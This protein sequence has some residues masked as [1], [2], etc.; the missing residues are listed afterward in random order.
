M[1]AEKPNPGKLERGA[2]IS[3]CE[4]LGRIGDGGFGYI[5]KVRRDGKVYALK[6]A[7][8]RLAD[9]PAEDRGP[10][11]ERLH[12]EVAALMTLHHPNIVRIHSFDR[13]PE[14]EDGYPYLVMDYVEGSCIYEWRAEAKPSLAQI[15]MVFEKIAG[16]VGHMHRL[17]IC[18]RDLKSANVIVRPD[19]E[20]VIVDFGLARS[21]VAYGVTQASSI[22]TL[23]HYPPEYAAYCDSAAYSRQP[24]EWPPTTDIYTL[25]YVLYVTL[26]GETPLTVVDENGALSEVQVLDRIKNEVPD[27]CASRKSQNCPTSRELRG[28][29]EGVGGSRSVPLRW[30][31]LL[32]S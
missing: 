3:S 28:A 9:L 7:R 24:F 4:I 20:P 30:G 12:R 23:T 29:R 26:A 13:W 15:C 18:H 5:F 14:I 21:Q 11:E 16:A 31:S 25:G 22:G 32:P 2:T 17:G 8:H 1:S 6:I 27:P 19:G 10:T